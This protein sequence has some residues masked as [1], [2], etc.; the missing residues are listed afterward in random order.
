MSSS[1]SMR[2]AGSLVAARCSTLRSSRNCLHGTATQPGVSG[3]QFPGLLDPSAGNSSYA[4][5]INGIG[6]NNGNVANVN[7]GN[8]VNVAEAIPVDAGYNALLDPKA[9]PFSMTVW[10]KGNPA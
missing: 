2:C 3:P 6:G 10:F 5:A 7:I 4:V 1:S 8:N 9:P